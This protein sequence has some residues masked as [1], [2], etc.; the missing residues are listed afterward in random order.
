M[1]HALKRTNSRASRAADAARTHQ[2]HVTYGDIFDDLGF[3]PKKAASLKLKAGLHQE[4]V[5]RA[6]RYSQRELQFLLSESQSRVS[7]LLHGKIAGF[8]LEMLIFYAERLGI[9]AEIKTTQSR[10]PAHPQLAPLNPLR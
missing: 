7:Q 8:T 1:H 6:E 4:I 3:A 9:H 5:R 10:M 2:E